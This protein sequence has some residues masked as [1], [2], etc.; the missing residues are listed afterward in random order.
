MVADSR[1]SPVAGLDSSLMQLRRRTLAQGWI[2]RL[3]SIWALG[4]ALICLAHDASCATRNVKDLEHTGV[5]LVDPW[6]TP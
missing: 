4:I 2:Q 3:T 1:I 6:A 5:S